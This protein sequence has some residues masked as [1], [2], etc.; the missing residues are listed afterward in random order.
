MGPDPNEIS[1]KCFALKIILHGLDLK[2]FAKIQIL[3]KAGSERINLICRLKLLEIV[4][5][6]SDSVCI[7]RLHQFN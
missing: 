5:V 3:G 4:G 2:E 7:S 6:V 1:L